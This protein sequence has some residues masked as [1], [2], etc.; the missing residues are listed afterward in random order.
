MLNA[1]EHETL[2][3]TA[4]AS[5]T[6][7]DD[8]SHRLIVTYKDGGEVRLARTI[9]ALMV[10]YVPPAWL[11]ERP[12]V[13]Y[14][15]S[16]RNARARRGFD[17]EALVSAVIA[18]TLGLPHE[19]LFAPPRNRDQRAL[20]RNERAANMEHRMQ[21]LPNVTAPRACLIIDDVCTTGATLYSTADALREAGTET[22]F[23]LTFARA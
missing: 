12:V 3:F 22:L 18:E 1:S 20:T 6:A 8:A 17:H 13:T 5:V 16:T 21:L 9:G 15:P 10:P 2:P 14:V 7:L 11:R 19:L 4:M 23:A